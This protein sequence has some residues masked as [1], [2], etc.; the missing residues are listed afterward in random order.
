MKPIYLACFIGLASLTPMIGYAAPPNAM[1][2]NHM[3]AQ[4]MTAMKAKLTQAENLV[5]EIN[6][7]YHTQFAVGPKEAMMAMHHMA[8]ANMEM[9][10][11]MMEMQASWTASPSP[12]T[13]PTPKGQ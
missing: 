5:A 2:P 13:F 6:R 10:K 9:A 11:A 1:G 8:M 3:S 12:M 7:S 4:Q